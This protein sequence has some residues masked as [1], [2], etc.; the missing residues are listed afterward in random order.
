MNSRIRIGTSGW[1]Y[2]HWRGVFYPESLP[3]ERWLAHYAAVFDT[4]EINNT[5]Y[6]QPAPDTVNRWKREAPKGFVY[7]IK[8]NRY[9][10]HMKKLKDPKDPLGRF[11]GGARRLGNRLGPVLYQLPPRWSKNVRRLR[12]FVRL[13]PR[14]LTHAIEFRERSWLAADTYAV[15]EE[16]GVCLC[17]HDML[18]RHPRRMS[19]PAVYLRLHG[20]GQTYG[21]RYPLR[22]LRSWADWIAEAAETRPAFVYFNN[23]AE[24]HAVRDALRLRELLES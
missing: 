16:H 17:V 22:R 24:G 3:Q 23:D 20:A 12:E 4:V 11:L 8:A 21:G 13:L 18:P 1:D 15:L 14:D 6:H 19:G 5:F 9:I 2:A 10:T 7:A